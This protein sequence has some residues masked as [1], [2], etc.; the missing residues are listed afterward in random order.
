MFEFIKQEMPRLYE[1]LHEANL[2]QQNNMVLEGMFKN[3]SSTMFTSQMIKKNGVNNATRF[4]ANNPDYMDSLLKSGIAMYQAETYY[5]GDKKK[6]LPTW[7]KVQ[8]LS[9]SDILLAANNYKGN[10]EDDTGAQASAIVDNVLDSIVKNLEELFNSPEYKNLAE[11]LK[12]QNRDNAVN[13]ALIDLATFAKNLSEGKSLITSSGNVI[14]SSTGLSPEDYGGSRGARNYF[15][16]YGMGY[17][18]SYDLE[19]LYIQAAKAENLKGQEK[20]QFG[21]DSTKYEGQS[22]EDILANLN[23]QEKA[24]IRITKAQ[25]DSAAILVEMGNSLT[26]IF[27]DVGKG[28]WEKPFEK[29]GENLV[30]GKEAGE[31]MDEVFNHLASEIMQASGEAMVKAGWELVARGAADRNYAM[32]ASGLALAGAGAFASGVG[33]AMTQEDKEAKDAEDKA[34]RLEDLRNSLADLLEQAR[35][36]AL[37]YEHNLRH[38]TALG[39]NKGF[40]HQTVNDAVITPSGKVVTTDPKDYLIA[41]KTPSQ[42]VGG[43]SNVSVSPVI[44][45]NVINN[46]SSRVTQQQRQNPDGSIDIVTM[47]EDAV[48]EYIASPRSDN[49][50]ESRQY[51]LS[52]KQAVM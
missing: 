45:C 12:N 26:K 50:F 22:D 49:A 1:E 33:N 20:N 41:T 8:G 42:L 35:T 32:I 19:D 9:V 29:M 51:R 15:L 38:K 16:K 31:D 34:Q 13:N 5:N 6:Y 44:N 2:Q 24:W 36:D 46:T 28:M 52:S 18:Q 27:T 10:K 23:E 3:L 11:G 17:E 21:I 40:S 14:N 25:E 30:L 47:I 48:G 43:G 4:I 7:D 37:Y 39:I